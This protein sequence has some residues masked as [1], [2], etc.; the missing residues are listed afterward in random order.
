MSANFRD[1]PQA[2]EVLFFWTEKAKGTNRKARSGE[3]RAK[4]IDHARYQLSRQGVKAVSLK[5]ARAHTGSNIS[6]TVVASFVRQL[7]V[8][9]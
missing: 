7:A 3:I 5:K 6:L 1:K 8:M 4:S 9:L 2:G